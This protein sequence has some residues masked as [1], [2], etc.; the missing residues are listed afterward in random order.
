[1]KRIVGF[2]MLGISLLFIINAIFG[3]YIVLPGYLATLAANTGDKIPEGISIFKILRYLLWAFSFKFGIYFFILGVLF[4]KD[5]KISEKIAFSI[6]GF[7]YICFAYIDLPFRYSLY[8]GI[9]GGIITIASLLLLW[10]M[11]DT[12][13]TLR[14][15]RLFEYL[16]FFFLI[17]AAYNLCPFC[18][19]KCFALYP[20]KMIQY[21]LQNEAASFANHIMSEFILGFLFIL[22]SKIRLIR[23]RD[24][25]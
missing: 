11:G 10:I 14:P 13:H 15:N 2:I 17:M 6:I 22:L 4:Y 21:N 20:E 7:I 23:K 12:D 1:M 19:V 5:G 24:N 8:F 25:K 16:G 3:R 9:G 18:G